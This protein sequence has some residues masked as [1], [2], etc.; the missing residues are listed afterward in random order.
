MPWQR[1]APR[2]SADIC[3]QDA[4]KAQSLDWFRSG[5]AKRI[6]SLFASALVLQG[7]PGCGKSCLARRVIVESG[8]EV[9]EYGPHIEMPLP[10]FLRNL[11][12]VDCEGRR[13]CLLVDDLPQVMEQKANVG[14]GSVAVYFPVVC[15]A[16]FIAKRWNAT[17]GLPWVCH[18]EITGVSSRAPPETRG[19]CA[20]RRR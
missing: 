20:C 14:A 13:N 9:V 15:T 17:S 19:S 4:A 2:T 10:Q 1:F 11:G 6:S 12:A 18:P 8:Y 16:D 7:P 3:G 5:S